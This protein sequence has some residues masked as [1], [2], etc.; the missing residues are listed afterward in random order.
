MGVGICLPGTPTDSGAP[1]FLV[2]GVPVCLH[3]QCHRKPPHH[4][5]GELWFPAPHTHVFSTLKPGCHRPLLFPSHFPKDTGEFPHWEED[6]LLPGLHGS[7]LL[8]SLSGRCHGLLH[9]SDGLWPPC[10][11]LPAP[12]LSPSW[13][14]SSVWG[15]RWLAVWEASY[16]PFTNWLWCSHC[17]S[18]AQIS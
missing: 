8:L 2:S 7:G 16:I 6:H 1:S 11:H 10:C 4:D 3:H 12:P 17:L 18:V 13:T 5:H 14:L 9:F 15:W